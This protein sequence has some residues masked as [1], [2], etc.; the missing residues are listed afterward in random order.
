MARLTSTIGRHL[1]WLW[2]FYVEAR[3]L[4]HALRQGLWR[5]LSPRGRRATHEQGTLTWSTRLPEALDAAELVGILRR[6]GVRVHEGGN[7]FYLPP[8]PRLADVLGEAVERYPPGSGFKVLRDFG[9]LDEVHYLHPRRQTRLRRRLIGR[10]Q[11][12]LVAAN[13]LHR[14]GYGPRVW[15]VCRLRARPLAMTAFVVQH[16]EGTVPTTDEC[17]AFMQRLRATLAATELRISV[18][19]WE[20]HKDFRCPSCNGNLLRDASGRLSFVDFQNFS[21]RHPRRLLAATMTSGVPLETIDS[22]GR[23]GS[24]RDRLREHG[25]ELR[26]RLVLHLGC[27]NGLL[28]RQ[29]LAAGA[30]WGLGWDAEPAAR[31]AAAIATACGF[32]RVDIGPTAAGE[33][34]DVA[35]VIPAWLRDHLPEAVVVVH[36][37]Q[38]AGL[39]PHTLGDMPWR[40]LVLE[41]DRP[42]A[43]ESATARVAA[44]RRACAVIREPAWTPVRR[45]FIDH[46]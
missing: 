22:S 25:V 39:V 3:L 13:Y 46:R 29:A 4:A 30:W 24:L 36:L 10:P 18:P 23:I 38:V 19:D 6:A 12:Q 2:P 9:R 1:P 31:E 41:S 14:L 8:Q 40:A 7:A 20:H 17:R 33:A 32:T 27:R 43:L 5:P 26:N 16:V 11:D 37:G 42:E 28:L 45:V 15:D 21:I 35:A 34:L 44:G